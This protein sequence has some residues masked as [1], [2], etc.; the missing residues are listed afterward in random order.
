[1]IRITRANKFST[2]LNDYKSAMENYKVKLALQYFF[3]SSVVQ[4]CSRDG[5][6]KYEFK[7]PRW[8]ARRANKT[9]ESFTI[10]FSS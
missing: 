6:S 4:A 7:E 9:E 5:I 8:F 2:E 1:M 10:D 3:F